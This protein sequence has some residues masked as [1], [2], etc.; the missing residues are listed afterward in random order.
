MSYYITAH[1]HGA[2]INMPVE[3]KHKYITDTAI[4][5]DDGADICGYSLL[6]ASTALYGNDLINVSK[7]NFSNVIQSTVSETAP[8]TGTSKSVSGI[9]NGLNLSSGLIRLFYRP[10][11]LTI[12]Q[13][14]GSRERIG[15]KVFLK[16]VQ[17]MIN[18]SATQKWFTELNPLKNKRNTTVTTFR[19]TAYTTSGGTTGTI[20]TTTH[21][22]TFYNEI[23]WRQNHKQWAKFRIMLVRFNDLTDQQSSSESTLKE[24]V[25]DWFNTI[26]VPSMIIPNDT[27]GSGDVPVYKDILVV[28][29]QSKLLRESTNY[30]GKYQIL[31]DQIIELNNMDTNKFI[32][33]KLD[34]KMNLTFKDDDTPTAEKYNNVYGFIIPP[35]FYKMDMDTCTYQA[36]ETMESSSAALASFS[37]NIKFT[38][39]DI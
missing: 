6:L 29:N 16:T 13:G 1:R 22:A 25:Q 2:K 38:Y 4:A 28:S 3:E 27:Y 8:H 26:F 17:I 19:P 11:Q 24:Y 32:T 20:S 31:H 5:T 23:N 12:K 7:Q 18:L 9:I 15:D 21:D 30:N 33:I 39:Y 14:T 36:I 10:Q 34:P 35:T 37:T